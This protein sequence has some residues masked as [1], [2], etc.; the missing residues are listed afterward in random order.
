MST[1]RDVTKTL[2]VKEFVAELRRFADTIEA[3]KA[4]AI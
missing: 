2:A 1:D 3:G 4:F